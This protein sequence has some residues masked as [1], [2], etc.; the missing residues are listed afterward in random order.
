[1]G[2]IVQDKIFILSSESERIRSD[3]PNDNYSIQFCKQKLLLVYSSWKVVFVG[4]NIMRFSVTY[5]FN[6]P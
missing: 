5:Y 6:Q 2:S 1:M 4:Q 3:V